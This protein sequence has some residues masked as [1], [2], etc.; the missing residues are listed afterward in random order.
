MGALPYWAGSDDE[1]PTVSQP[2]V[3]PLRFNVTTPRD[4]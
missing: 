4:V 1:A 3:H 2:P